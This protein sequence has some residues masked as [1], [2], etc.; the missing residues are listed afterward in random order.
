MGNSKRR[1]KLNYWA[2]VPR[3]PAAAGYLTA[4]VHG[5]HVKCI[6]H[7]LALKPSSTHTA[8][9]ASVWRSFGSANKRVKG[10]WP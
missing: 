4:P 5:A 3:S 9:F 6:F 1:Y 2:R 8:C 7:G 10:T